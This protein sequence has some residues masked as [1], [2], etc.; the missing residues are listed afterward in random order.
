M[1][2]VELLYNDNVDY[3]ELAGRIEFIIYFWILNWLW[4]FISGKYLSI[5]DSLA[6]THTEI[7]CMS[8]WNYLLYGY[9]D[10]LQHNH[11]LLSISQLKQYIYTK[12]RT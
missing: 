2:V 3:V 6:A 4:N 7:K 9:A 11:K 1:L 10:H 12:K 5:F 8:K